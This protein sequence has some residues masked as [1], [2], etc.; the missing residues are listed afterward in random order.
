MFSTI[1]IF[2]KLTCPI[3]KKTKT[4]PDEKQMRSFKTKV[5][6]GLAKK[7]LSGLI[8]KNIFKLLIPATSS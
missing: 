3:S 8:N 1:Y 6:A 4:F 7:R 5:L 2:L